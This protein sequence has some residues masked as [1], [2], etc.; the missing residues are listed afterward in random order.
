MRNTIF[1]LATMDTKADEICFVADAIR[2]ADLD[3]VLVDL[4]T[5]GHSDRADISAQT[6]AAAHPAGPNLVLEQTDRGQAVTAMA[7]ALHAWLP[8]QVNTKQVAGVIAIGGSGGTAIVAPAFQALPVG[9]PKLI[10]STV[11]SGN[12]QPY[13]GSSDITLMYSVVDVAGLNS[14]SRRI[15][16]N[17]AHAIAGMVANQTEFTED[18][19]ALGMTMFGVTTP[20]VDMVRESLEAKGFDPLVFHATGTGGRAMEKLVAD[21]LI[22][23]VLDITTTEVAD[24]VVGGI[25]SAGPRRF[26]IILERGIPYVMSLG[27]LDMVNFGARETVPEQFTDRRFLV[28]NPQVTLMR[29]T[30]DE[31]QQMAQWIAA[32][33][34]RSTAP[35]EILI[36][37]HGLSML[38]VEGAA[39]YDPTADQC[40]FE[41][42]EQ[43]V[44]QTDERRITRFPCH[45]ND[46]AFAEAL[47][48]AFERVSGSRFN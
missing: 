31:N 46:A 40:L 29:T 18:R 23:G 12:T 26:D 44:Q 28:H 32:K 37:E 38:D 5:R 25:M 6:I 21:G 11:A 13:V 1:A 24:E 8:D 34:N 43:E 30:V 14:V 15:L 42:L 22:G 27:A 16:S 17:A 2:N 41:T 20:C 4:S 36:P 3:V 19:P 47:V 48:A 39:F 35:I 33:V 10:L 45:I 9:F 7:A